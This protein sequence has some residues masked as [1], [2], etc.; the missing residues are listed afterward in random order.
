MSSLP[1]SSFAVDLVSIPMPIPCL[2]PKC[3]LL[4]GL[5]FTTLVIC[6]QQHRKCQRLTKLLLCA[7]PL[8]ISPLNARPA[9]Q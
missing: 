3:P 8:H 5:V 1:V 9:M 7:R 6:S 2:T 4:F